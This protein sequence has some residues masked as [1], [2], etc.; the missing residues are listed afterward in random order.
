[1]TELS[2]FVKFITPIYGDIKWHGAHVEI[3][4]KKRDDFDIG[5]SYAAESMLYVSKY[6]IPL[7]FAVNYFLDKY[8]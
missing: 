3:R 5:I 2:D 4:E 1:M 8:L 6:V 7:G